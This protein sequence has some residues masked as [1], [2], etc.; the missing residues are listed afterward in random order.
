LKPWRK[1]SGAITK[2]LPSLMAAHSLNP[3]LNSDGWSQLSLTQAGVY[4]KLQ[5]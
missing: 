1:Q 2:V 3:L 4:L 5:G